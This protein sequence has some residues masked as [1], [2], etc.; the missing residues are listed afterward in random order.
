M[1][2]CNFSVVPEADW[3]HQLLDTHTHTPQQARLGECSDVTS[4]ELSVIWSVRINRDLFLVGYKEALRHVSSSVSE[5]S[6]GKLRCLTFSLAPI[7]QCQTV[8]CLTAL[9]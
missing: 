7:S 2:P 4:T 8:L 6:G 5:S 9:R 3:K 1:Q